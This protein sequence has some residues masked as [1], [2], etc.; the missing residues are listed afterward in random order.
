[1]LN[2]KLTIA[3]L[4]ATASPLVSGHYNFLPTTAIIEALVGK[5]FEVVSAGQHNTKDPAMRQFARHN[6]RLRPP[7]TSLYA[8]G[9]M[10]SEINLRNAHQSGSLVG[11]A[12][13][14]VTFC[15]N[16]CMRP[17]PYMHNECYFRHTK[18]VSMGDVIEG[19]FKVVERSNEWVRQ[20]TEWNRIPVAQDDAVE[21][22]GRAL[23]L[24]W[25]HGN[26]P[27]APEQVL[28]PRYREESAQTLGAVYNRLHN[29]AQHG[30]PKVAKGR[31]A[32]ALRN[33]SFLRFNEGLAQIVE[34]YAR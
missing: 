31:V 8:V 3:A 34:G 1:M 13:A 5:G 25:P 9:D 24:R 33:D 20:L 18:R 15:S 12:S 14:F 2:T 7:K 10:V 30:I 27:L 17:V 22:A 16:Q 28:V 23:L 11:D 4:S 32:R 21:M 26:T 29:I 6:V 19:V